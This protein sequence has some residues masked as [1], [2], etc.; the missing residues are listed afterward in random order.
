MGL[1]GRSKPRPLEATHPA[2]QLKA[3]MDKD[4]VIGLLG[5][6][7]RSAA[8][9]E[10]EYWLYS[11][12]RNDIE[13][14]F[15]FGSLESARVKEKKPD[16]STTL[17]MEI[18]EDEPAAA[19]H[20]QGPRLCPSCGSPQLLAKTVECIATRRIDAEN[21]LGISFERMQLH[22]GDCGFLTNDDVHGTAA[23]AYSR[24]ATGAGAPQPR[25]SAMVDDAVR[26]AR[27]LPQ[28][29]DAG[30]KQDYD[31]VQGSWGCAGMV[32]IP[33]GKLHD[34]LTKIIRGY[35][36]EGATGFQAE[37]LE[38]QVLMLSFLSEAGFRPVRLSRTNCGDFTV[39]GQIQMYRILGIWPTTS[40]ERALA[41]YRE[42]HPES[43]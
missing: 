43:R 9:G 24:L 42:R 34:S 6:D 19:E 5:E 3:G 7:Y 22:C 12:D 32:V 28:L 15:R 40:F 41:R 26:Q 14:A 29:S 21:S 18:D 8:R 36:A 16:G 38:G 20:Y 35:F 39:Y 13:I 23:I 31:R 2:L 10:M 25:V 37:I 1:F 4:A 17:L 27:Q 30:R 33:E 11:S